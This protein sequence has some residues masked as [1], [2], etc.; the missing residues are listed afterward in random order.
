MLQI[1]DLDHTLLKTNSSSAFFK[2]LIKQ[3]IIPKTTRIHALFL[4][5]RY[6]RRHLSLKQ[7]HTEIFERF[8]IGRKINDLKNHVETFL[9]GFL[10][11]AL[12]FELTSVLS[13]AQHLGHVTALIS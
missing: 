10:D 11:K 5:L 7:L 1:F 8:L 2:Y 6:H 3:K 13:R 12:S 9:D 4:A